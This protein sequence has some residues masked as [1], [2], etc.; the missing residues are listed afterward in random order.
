[1]AMISHLDFVIAVLVA[2]DPSIS[3]NGSSVLESPSIALRH[4]SRLPFPF[5]ARVRLQAI[6]GVLERTGTRGRA[7]Q[8]ADTLFDEQRMCNH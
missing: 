6:L 2:A 1:M 4:P 3:R 7:V 8:W 5:R